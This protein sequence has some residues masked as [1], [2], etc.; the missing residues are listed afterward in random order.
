MP[1][2]AQDCKRHQGGRRGF[3]GQLARHHES[4]KGSIEPFGQPG[5]HQGGRKGSIG[6]PARHQG[7]TRETCR[8]GRSNPDFGRAPDFLSLLIQLQWRTAR[9][10][11]NP[12]VGFPQ[13]RMAF[14]R[15]LGAP[16]AQNCL[17][18]TACSTE[19]SLKG[20]HSTSSASTLPS[21]RP[22]VVVAQIP[23]L[24]ALVAQNS[25][26]KVLVAQN[27]LLRALVAQIP[28]LKGLV[29]RLFE[30]ARSKPPGAPT[31][32]PHAHALASTQIFGQLGFQPKYVPAA[33]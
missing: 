25:L 32:K 9:F 15:P 19:S 17:S 18:K 22:W 29:S 1:L 11:A 14:K 5:R 33:N 20:L 3:I 6:Q 21:W 7:G 10:A 26:L 2:G 13:H 30:T 28:L 24:Q 4:R 12:G 31:T 16:V 8:A 23:L 27:P